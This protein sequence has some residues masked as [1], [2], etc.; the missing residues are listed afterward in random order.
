MVSSVVGPNFLSLRLEG[1]TSLIDGVYSFGL[2]DG[3]GYLFGLE[4][5]C[6]WH[7]ELFCGRS[8]F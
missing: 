2:Y 7:D 5:E 8:R 6:A 3:F 4:N 1:G